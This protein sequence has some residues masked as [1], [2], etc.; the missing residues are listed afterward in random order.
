MTPKN[1]EVRFI[2]EVEKI[3]HDLARVADDNQLGDGQR[4]LHTS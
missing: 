4:S 1:D 3:M 2:E